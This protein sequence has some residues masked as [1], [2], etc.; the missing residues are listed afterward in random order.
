MGYVTRRSPEQPAG[1]NGDYP[2]TGITLAA[3]RHG[4]LRVAHEMQPPIAPIDRPARRFVTTKQALLVELGLSARTVKL[5]AAIENRAQQMAGL[6]AKP[7]HSLLERG[8]HIH[9]FGN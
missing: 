2:G 8:P 6:L 3:S 4:R 1:L 9:T 5:V 7:D